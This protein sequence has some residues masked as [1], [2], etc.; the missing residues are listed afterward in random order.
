M[1]LIDRLQ[2]LGIRVSKLKDQVQTEEA[3]KNA[4]IMPFLAALGYDVFNPLEVIPEFVADLGTKKGEKVDYCILMDGKPAII[5]EAKHWSEKMDV[6]KSQLHRYFH[7]TD[8]RFGILTNGID[9][10][11]YTD[12]VENNKMDDKPFF[13]FSIEELNDSVIGELKKFQKTRFDAEK[14]FETASGLRYSKEIKE[15][16]AKELKTPSEEFVKFFASQIY[17]G[18][19]TSSVR[20]QFTILVAKSARELI[21]ELISERLKIAESYEEKGG[22]EVAPQEESV[23]EEQEEG[24]AGIITTEEE[25]QGFRIVQAIIGKFVE[26]TRIFHRDTKSYMGILLDD[27]NRKQ[28]CRLHLNRENAKYL[29]VFDES[30][31]EERIPINSIEDIFQ[32]EEKL[33]ATIQRLLEQ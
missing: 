30:K 14:I 26:V 32:H 19:I 12:L 28:I 4:F 5:L 25:L 23:P 21:S 29:G 17:P 13:E 18:R 1:D 10:R 11:F 7:V 31:N 2:E 15:L 24:K 20:E 22:E 6:H 33:I 27:N 3:T 16:L 8:A 9:Y